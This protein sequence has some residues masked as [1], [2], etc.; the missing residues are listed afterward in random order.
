M[1][2]QRKPRKR[3]ADSKEEAVIAMIHAD[4]QINPPSGMCE[5]ARQGVIFHEIIDEFAKVDWSKHTIRLAALLATAI[6]HMQELQE[7]LADEGYTVQTPKGGVGINP[8]ASAANQLAGQIMSQRRT[9][10]LH[11]IAGKNAGDVGKR[12]SINKGN[13][14]NSPLDDEDFATP[15]QGRA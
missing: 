8:K 1:P 12:R 2:S 14:A 15:K 9:L 6:D 5:T 11:A 7:D 10:A 13:Q 4:K 3:R